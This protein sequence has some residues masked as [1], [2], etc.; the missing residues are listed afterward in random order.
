MVDFDIKNDKFSELPKTNDLCL[1]PA[2][3]IK[4]KYLYVL[5][6]FERK[7]KFFEK[8]NLEKNEKIS[9]KNYYFYK[10]QDLGI[11]ESDNNDS[12]ILGRGERTGLNTIVYEID[13]NSLV[14]SK[15]KD[16]TCK[17]EDK[18]FYKVNNNYC[19]NIPI[20]KAPK[21]KSIIIYGYRF[22]NS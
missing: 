5:D 8:I 1:K 22:K 2:L 21:E 16:Q 10:N 17:F 14:K 11:C 3:I 20:S 15:G 19:V 12:I 7:K 13:I 4:N 18:A 9:P 6:S